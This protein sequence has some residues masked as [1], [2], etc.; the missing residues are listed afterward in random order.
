MHICGWF[1]TSRQEIGIHLNGTR[2]E[3]TTYT[4]GSI[5][6]GGDLIIGQEQDANAGSFDSAQAYRWHTVSSLL[7]V[8][9]GSS[10]PEY[11]LEW[12]EHN[13]EGQSFLFFR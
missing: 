11:F 8:I 10:L 9:A 4:S 2:L 6:G 12:Q 13:M 1:S 7:N 3:S 5:Q